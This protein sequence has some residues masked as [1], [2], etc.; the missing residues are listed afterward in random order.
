MVQGS[1]SY[2]QLFDDGYTIIKKAALEILLEDIFQLKQENHKMVQT[3]DVIGITHPVWEHPTGGPL[4]I[5]DYIKCLNQVND[6]ANA[7]LA[8]VKKSRKTR[9]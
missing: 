6:D 4:T 3:L 1:I 8:E 9:K 5:E 2:Q 7:V